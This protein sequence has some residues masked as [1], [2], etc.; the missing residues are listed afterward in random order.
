MLDKAKH[1]HGD[2]ERDRLVERWH[3]QLPIFE[4]PA[5][6]KHLSDED[7]LG[8]HQRFDQRDAVVQINDP[9][10]GQNQAPIERERGRG[11]PR[12]PDP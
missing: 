10:L 5:Q 12:S 4:A 8:D 6:P 11:A 7:N 3:D 2:P 1:D 9:G